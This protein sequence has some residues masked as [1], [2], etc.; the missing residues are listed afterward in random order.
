MESGRF[1]VVVA[2]LALLSM[3]ALGS[4]YERSE[5][6]R[7]AFK[8]QQPCP[9]TGSPSGPC[10][11]WIIDHI[12]PLACDGPDEPYNMQWQTE[13]EAKAKD[14]WERN[15]CSHY[16]PRDPPARRIYDAGGWH[17]YPGDPVYEE[18]RPPA[19]PQ[20]DTPTGAHYQPYRAMPPPQY[21][22][23]QSMGPP[24]YQTYQPITASPYASPHESAPRHVGPRGGIFHYSRSGKKVYEERR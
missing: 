4:G 23:Y 12:R 2:G 15:D 18:A 6:A 13:E 7:N 8:A 9:A 21:Q 19:E 3:A 20:S 17:D 1:R 14:S 11:G 5:A 10:P 16:I 22:R 24:Q